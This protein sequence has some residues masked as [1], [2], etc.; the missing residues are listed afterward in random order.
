MHKF[1]GF[2]YG[3]FAVGA[4]MLII[5]LALWN[6]T[7]YFIAHAEKADGTVTKMLE[8][9]DKDDNSPMYRPVVAFT[10]RKGEAVAFTSSFSSRPPAYVVGESVE[11]LYDPRN[12]LDARINGFGSLWLGPWILGGL[13]AL[14]TAVG[15]S[16][17]L[18]GRMGDRK[19]NYLMAYGNALQTDLQGVDR[20]TSLTVN[21]RNPWR[22]TSQ[23]LDPASNKLRIFHSENLWFDPAKFLTA[24]QVTVLLDPNDPKSYYMDLSFLPQSDEA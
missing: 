21:G 17:V 16:I 4:L 18:A 3:A 11:V 20:N 15:V 9:L 23:W 24:K 5:S 6:K 22:V 13:G 14:F 19:K 12:T 2:S 10:T 1:R 8:V 7:R